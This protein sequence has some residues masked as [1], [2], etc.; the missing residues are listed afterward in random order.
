[1]AD[2][3][4]DVQEFHFNENLVGRINNLSLS[5]SA[6][7]ALFP[8]F[9]AISNSF[10]AI[11]ERFGEEVQNGRIS[12]NLFREKVEQ[13]KG[14]VWQVRSIEVID[15]GIGLT[16]EN[17][18]SFRTYDSRH[19]LEKGGK[20]VGRLTWLKV[21][22]NT[23]IS[24]VY[25]HDGSKKRWNFNFSLDNQKAFKN[26]EVFIEK[27]NTPFETIVKL[28]GMR[29]EYFSKCPKKT[30]TIS[31][32]VVSHFLKFLLAPKCPS[33]LLWD[34]DEEIDLRER[35]KNGIR[36]LVEEKIT[37]TNGQV[38]ALSHLLV[39]KDVSEKKTWTNALVFRAWKSS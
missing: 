7:N 8:L 2:L 14:D 24:S 35:A 11:E 19:K 3:L 5:P 16:E 33:I 6:E 21:F 36:K 1:M 30:D 18:L 37:L 25:S 17:M 22:N 31:S 32:Y 27:P 28:D 9:E 34:G 26:H 13:E 39:S 10:H 4:D 23:F 15:N 12:V 38:L 29:S 20:G